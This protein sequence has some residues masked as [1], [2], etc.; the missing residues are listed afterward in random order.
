[1]AV[2]IDDAS[3]FEAALESWGVPQA[4]KEKLLAKGYTTMSLVAH[5]LPAPDQLESFVISV[6]GR[7]SG[8]AP[9]D[10]V[11]SPAASA[12]RRVV[13]E[14]TAA[15]SNSPAIPSIGGLPSGTVLAAKPKLAAADV[16]KLVTDFHNKYPSEFLR[17]ET[18]P[19]LSLL[20]RVKDGL[21]SKNLGW[22]PWRF[23]TSE[24]EEAVVERRRPRTEVAMLSSLLAAHEPEPCQASVPSGGPLEPTLRRFFGILCTAI[25]LLDGMHLLPL[26]KMMEKFVDLAI[27]IPDDKTLRG[28]LLS[29][30]IEA[31]RTL[32]AGVA[33]LQVE[34]SWS[35]ADAVAEMTQIRPDLYAA[36][37]PR[38]R[39]P[40]PDSTKRKAPALDAAPRAKAP[41]RSRAKG[42]GRKRSGSGAGPKASAK[43]APKVTV[44]AWPENW[45]RSVDGVGPCIRFHTAKCRNAK[46]RFSHACPI[47][48]ASGVP[49]GQPH[50]AQDHAKAPH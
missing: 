34:H 7:P 11:I 50:S 48:N 46:C 2:R 5:A 31:D 1:M 33:S 44:S 3:F 42:S 8:L 49:C 39:A 41:S 19:S 30:A 15:A 9:E 22:I 20:L 45:A 35:L 47:L 12:L 24:Q 32:W 28:P 14:C 13:K 25:A 4:V 43:A 40:A 18:M 29:E 17:P 38:V 36:L 37:A 6:L 26:R 21:D 16:T 23:R 10:P 27:K